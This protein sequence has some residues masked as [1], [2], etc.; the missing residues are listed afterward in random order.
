[1]ESPHYIRD[2][3]FRRRNNIG[4]ELVVGTVENSGIPWWH[5]LVEDSIALM[6]NS[7]C[8]MT[9]G[10]TRHA[11]GEVE[12]KL[13]LTEFARPVN[14]AW[15]SMLENW[16]NANKKY[17]RECVENNLEI[18]VCLL[19]MSK[20]LWRMLEA[21]HIAG[22]HLRKVRLGSGLLDVD[23]TKL[24]S[25]VG[26]WEKSLK[27]KGVSEI[28]IPPSLTMAALSKL[29]A[30]KI[31]EIRRIPRTRRRMYSVSRRRRTTPSKAKAKAKAKTTTTTSSSIL[32]FLTAFR[33]CQRRNIPLVMRM[34]ESCMDAIHNEIRKYNR[35]LFLN[36]ARTWRH[37]GKG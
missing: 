17:K 9:R 26:W 1:M 33:C 2:L 4:Y 11:I 30:G 32:Q 37:G 31:D 23:K 15:M 35:K 16:A 12:M 27:R 21:M 3:N 25:I 19:K 24:R 22:K 10:A 13:K 34:E 7:E 8:Y 14:D 20:Y 28:P 29:K 18:Q 6:H 36:K 5:M